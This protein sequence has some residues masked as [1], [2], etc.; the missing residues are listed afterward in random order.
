MKGFL[1]KRIALKEDVLQDR[2]TYCLQARPRIFQP[3]NFTGWG[4][5][6][7]KLIAPRVRIAEKDGLRV[8]SSLFISG[9]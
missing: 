3:G 9:Q 8:S 5:E 4:S 6:G 2:K 1:S 7:V